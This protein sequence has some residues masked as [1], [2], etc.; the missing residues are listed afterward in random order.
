MRRSCVAL[1]IAA[2]LL[3]A[4]SL[5]PGEMVVR[6]WGRAPKGPPEPKR[7]AAARAKPPTAYVAETKTPPKLDGKLDDAV[8]KEA[9]VLRLA[10]TLD[11]SGPA[12]Q[13]TEVRLLR[14]AKALYVSARA[15]EPQM[16]RLQARR[17]EH[18]G[19]TWSDD[20]IEIFLGLRGSYC[21]FAVNAAG[22]TYDARD[23][24]ASW[25]AGAGF[26]AATLRG[27]SEWTAEVAIPLAKIAG[28]GKL[29]QE[30]TANFNRNRY[31]TGSLQESSWSPTYSGD[32]H[33]PARFGKMLLKP[34]PKGVESAAPEKKAVEVLPAAN[35]AG[36]A[37]FDLSGIPKGAK[38]YRA[39]LLVFRTRQVDGRMVEAMVDIKMYPLFSP[40][41]AGGAAKA[42]GKPLAL[43]GPWYDRFDATEAVRKFA[44]KP[45]ASFFV[46]ACPFWSAEATCLDI[47]YQGKP[48][49]VPP[50]VTGVKA[51]HRSGQTFIM[52]K[53]V[54]D[55]A[56]KDEITWK[57]LRA[58]RD[59]MDRKRR[60][61][62][63]VYRSSR[64]ITAATLHQAERIAVVKPLS[65][66]NIHGRNKERP[67]D[68]FIATAEVLNWHQNNPFAAATVEGQYG[69]DC[70][71]DRL[72]IEDGQAP[73]ARGTG[74][75]VHT[76]GKNEKAYYAVV[77]RID[78]VENTKDFA[79]GNA[80][81]RPASE[82]VAEP[83]PVLQ[84][85]MPK[86]PFFNYRDHRYHY[87]RWVT[88]PYS[89]K[90]YDYYN[91]SV[92][93][94]H[95]VAKEKAK[96]VP[97]E[98]N[99]H[100][101]GYSYWR[102]PYRIEPGSIVL[103]P[104]DFPVKSWWYGYHE[105]LGRLRS[106]KTG[107]VHNYTEKRLLWF[108]DWA[109]KRWPVDRSRILV[110]GCAGGASAGGALHLGIR[111]PDVFNLVI[112]GHG[113]PVYRAQ[114]R[115]ADQVERI[116]GKEQWA[117]KA[118]GGKPVFDELDLVSHVEKLPRKTDL[119]FLSVS[120]RTASALKLCEIYLIKGWPVAG[121]FA[122]GGTRYL[123]VS[124]GDTSPSV[125]RLDVRKDRPMLAARTASALDIVRKS[126]KNTTLHPLVWEAGGVVDEPDR[127]AFTF[128]GGGGDV[129]IT[130]RRLQKLKVVAGKSYAYELKFLKPR[131]PRSR[132]KTPE[133]ISGAVTVGK[134]GVLTIP[135][136]NLPRWK[137]RLT[138][139]AK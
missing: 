33:V 63:C 65:C 131:D 118:E 54:E 2:A 99:F 128:P 11:G 41:R 66:W 12:A 37:R 124:A 102:T 109:A 42:A 8:W 35:G 48:E 110:T 133:P 5:S 53:E 9:A 117:L 52:W 119:P 112:S 6:R 88:A 129:A 58:I 122:W 83:A 18:D 139:T 47:A 82:T 24:N 1:A 77:T 44:G 89:N 70:P 91:W 104:H 7:P 29:P 96:N 86:M 23:K 130:I 81:S 108:I 38:V 20:S 64:R 62:Y 32:S 92:G 28:T 84:G 59:A 121:S 116:W 137:C 78:G 73:L 138:V 34:P 39:E 127:C 3:S 55:L 85:E 22:S 100:R 61:R 25:N 30:W 67:I 13:P 49:K 10:R 123:I 51:F 74:L 107:M 75:Y 26:K 97:M 111:Y 17:R 114:G 68:R 80:P 136:G 132:A 103:A 79:A 98:L 87:V 113:E 72:V 90:P 105:S 120:G 50:Q 21:Q 94:P 76:A 95:E 125:V 135:A 60:V 45:T 134:D 43:L 19:A 69:R 101:D 57:E 15:F 27:K 106:W 40:F 14:D 56:G 93:V 46:K 71:M 4:A 16:S 126:G 31:V 115:R 36:V